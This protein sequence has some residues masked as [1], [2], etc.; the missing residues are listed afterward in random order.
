MTKPRTAEGYTEDQLE[1]VRATCLHLAS[2][3]GDLLD[4][5]A[6]VGGL[7]PSL[8]VGAREVERAHVGT[9]DLDLALELALLETGRYQALSARL[10]AGGFEPDKTAEG[11]VVRQRWRHHEAGA[12]IDFLMPPVTAD[13]RGGTLQNLEADL[14]AVVT[15]GLRLAFRDRELVPLEGRTLQGERLTRTVPVCGPG[16]FVILKALAFRDRGENKDAYDL[17]YV[18]RHCGASVENLAARTRTLL[19]DTEAP[20]AIGY[21]EDDFAEIDSTGPVRAAG[22]LGVVDDEAFRADVVGL[23]ARYLRAL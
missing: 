22:F 11:R 7:V 21:L 17:F 4:E 3:L 15:P 9:T 14:A 19:D 1:R 8:L 6:V 10:R 16:A 12:T 18:L 13:A 23:V 20:R 5:T 2:V